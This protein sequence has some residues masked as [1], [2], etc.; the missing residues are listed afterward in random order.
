MINK[1]GEI[2]KNRKKKKKNE[3]FNRRKLEGKKGFL[4][5][6]TCL[7]GQRLSARA[8]RKNRICRERM[9]L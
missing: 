1:R 2:K 6:F 7:Q 5:R 4:N 9:Q 3:K 8:H